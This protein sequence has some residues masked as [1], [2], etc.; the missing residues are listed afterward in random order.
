MP[1]NIDIDALERANLGKVV[2]PEDW[3][4]LLKFARA[5]AAENVKSM[6]GFDRLANTISNMHESVC[7]SLGIDGDDA[8]SNLVAEWA[9]DNEARIAKLEAENAALRADAERYR[10]FCDAGWPVCFLGETYSDKASLDTAI[11]AGFPEGVDQ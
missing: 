5:S 3:S 1:D 8:L 11:D 9:E 7:K 6:R 4:A 2:R 10:K